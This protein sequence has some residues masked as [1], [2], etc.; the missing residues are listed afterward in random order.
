MR[1]ITR[2]TIARPDGVRSVL[3]VPLLLLCT[4]SFGQTAAVLQASGIKKLSVFLGTWKAESLVDAAHPVKTSA[5]YTCQWSANGRYLV[6]DQLVSND[7]KE[8]NNLSIYHYNSDKDDY[9]LSLVGIPGMQ[10]FTVPVT[11]KADT[12]FYSGEYTDNGK[13]VYNRTLNIFTS[14]TTYVYKIQFSDDGVHW[15]TDGEGKAMK[16]P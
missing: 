2:L 9:T 12:L 6:A 4:A 5:V 13:K 3:L 8:T 15:R 10:P 1:K 11:Y 16:M 7:G 14:A